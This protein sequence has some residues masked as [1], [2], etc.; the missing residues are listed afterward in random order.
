MF[1]AA[2]R[3]GIQGDRFMAQLFKI[4]LA[5]IAVLLISCNQNDSHV[6]KVGANNWLGYQPLFVA[7]AFDFYDKNKINVVEL[8]SAT[9]V[10]RALYNGGVDVAAVTLD[11]AMSALAQGKKIKVLM[12]ADFSYGG[13]AL[14]VNGAIESLS[15]LK[16]KTIGVEN[17]ALGAIMLDAILNKAQLKLEDVNIAPVTFDQHGRFLK[18]GQGDALITFEPVR[19]KLLAQSYREVFNSKEIPGTI[20][21][22]IVVT[23][24]A[25]KQYPQRIKSI[26]DGFFKARD[27]ISKKDIQAIASVSKRVGLTREAVLL[28]YDQLKLPSLQENIVL[29]GQCETGFSGVVDRLNAIMVAREM[30]QEMVDFSAACDGNLIQELSL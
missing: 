7:Q 10:L 28:G 4:M 11:E 20:V 19:S 12:V 21:D 29:M 27:L 3:M 8:G 24:Q 23:E 18:E 16:G 2:K 30:I 14:I 5:C 17:T 15:E 26:L 6:L 25:Y 22:V 1:D 9:G 13:D